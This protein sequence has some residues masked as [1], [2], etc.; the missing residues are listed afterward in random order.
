MTF[1]QSELKSSSELSDFGSACERINSSSKIN[2]AILFTLCSDAAVFTTRGNH[3][4][5]RVYKKVLFREYED[6]SF[7]TEKPHP[8]Y[9]GFLGPILKGEVG[10]TIEVHFKNKADRNFSVHP[11]GV[12]YLKDSEGALYEDQTKGANKRD[13]HVPPGGSHV[14]TWRLTQDHAPADDD[15]DCLT[16]IY[17][18]HLLPHKDIN[19]GLLGKA[20]QNLVSSSAKYLSLKL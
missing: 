17:H 5:G 15:D 7:N 14:Y 8:P 3:R 16:W 13:D 9:L 20:D 6:A 4:I 10:D 1:R 12:F 18:S 2:G 19:T 11:H